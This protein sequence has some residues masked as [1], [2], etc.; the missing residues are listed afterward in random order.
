MEET[1]RKTE[2][3]VGMFLTFGLVLLGLLILQFSSVRELFKDTYDLTVPFPDGTGIK[4]GTPVMLGG[5]KVGKVSDRPRLNEAFNGVIIP[6]EIYETVKIPVD[7]KFGIGTSGLLGDSY[8]EVRPSGKHTESYIEPG[9]V[10]PEAQVTQAGGLGGLQDTALNIGQKVDVAIEDV[11]AA[12]ADLR[13]SLKRINEGVLSEQSSADLKG[14]IASLNHV[15]K[16]LD[17]DTLGEETSKNLK[18][19]VESFKNVATSLEVSAKK[20]DPAIEKLDGAFG[21]TEALLGSADGAMKSIDK[22]AKE[23]GSVATDLRKGG[24]LL[25]ALLHDQ[26]LKQEFSSLISNLRQ[27]GILFYKDRS[28]EESGRQPETSRPVRPRI[29]R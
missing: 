25:P 18:T 8:V 10:I 29:G 22:S 7:A 13:L 20:L 9:T 16:R 24:G 3:L 6:L 15:V 17:E 26:E 11:R 4:V 28:G 23:I 12:V 19:A 21:K 5:S 1:D 14:A 2:L 27:R